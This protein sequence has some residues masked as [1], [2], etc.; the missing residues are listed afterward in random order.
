ME[1]WRHPEL[2]YEEHLAHA[3]LTAFLEQRGFLVERHYLGLETAFRATLP[4][5]AA[6]E[7]PTVAVCLEY[8]ALP[9]IGHACGHNLITEAGLACALGVKQALP[10][11]NLVVL[12]TP[13]EEGGGGKC[14]MLQRGAFAD[15]DAAMMVHPA[16]VDMCHFQSL[17]VCICVVRYHGRNAHAA[18]YPWEGVNALDA[19]IAAFNGVSLMRQQMKPDWRVHGVIHKG[20]EKPNIIPDLTEAEFYARAADDQDLKELRGRLARIFEGAALQAGATCEVEW[21]RESAY[22][23]VIT[24]APMAD[25]YRE[26]ARALGKHLR[27]RDEEKALGMGGSTDMGNVSLAVPT[28]HPLFRIQAK[29]GNHHAGFTECAGSDDA[30][31]QA[32]LAG[33]SMALTCLDLFLREGALAQ[34]KA[35]FTPREFAF[36]EE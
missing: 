26:N 35:D 21:H 23:Q 27:T 32:I 34:V 33:K 7:G 8:D 9:G 29:F 30:H 3:A 17:A 1:V 16:P 20:G 36:S 12:G 11:A 13:A 4:A 19:M 10:S 18:A 5:A 15:V 22:A 6:G 25:L 24:N 28:I 14:R 2:N 31:A